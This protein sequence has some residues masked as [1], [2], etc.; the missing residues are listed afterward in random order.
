MTGPQEATIKLRVAE[1]RFLA[2]ITKVVWQYA[3]SEKSFEQIAVEA[4]AAARRFAF[5]VGQREF[6]GIVIGQ[7]VD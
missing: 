2:S 7:P 6:L 5:R 1:L 3:E 4:Y